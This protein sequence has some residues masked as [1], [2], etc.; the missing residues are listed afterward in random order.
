MLAS[1]VVDR[2]FDPRVGITKTM[3][4]FAVYKLSSMQQGVR[5]N[6]GWLV[7]RTMSPSGATCLPAEL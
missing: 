1:S 3:K 7:I 2:G 6:T 5:S 4:L